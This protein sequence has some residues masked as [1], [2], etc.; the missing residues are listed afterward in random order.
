MVLRMMAGFG[1][2]IE[3]LRSS[4]SERV[5]SPEW[6]LHCVTA[7]SGLLKLNSFGVQIV[8]G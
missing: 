3:L 2:I 5:N 1:K 6:R 8:R 7:Y 4:D